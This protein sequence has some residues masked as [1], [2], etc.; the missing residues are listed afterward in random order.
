[1][2]T[3]KDDKE[4]V[5]LLLSDKSPKKYEGKEVIV[6]GGKVYLLPDDDKNAG[7]FL[8]KLIKK[9]PSIIPT[10]VSVPRHGMYI[11]LISK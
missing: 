1:M 11:L 2:K 6:L 7:L 10:L 8:N 9:N 5:N 4:I 3:Q